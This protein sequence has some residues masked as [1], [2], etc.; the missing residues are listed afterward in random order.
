MRLGLLPTVLVALAVPATASAHGFGRLYNLPVPFWLYAWAAAATLLLS[1]VATAFLVT[2]AAASQPKVKKEAVLTL[3]N[4]GWA[5]VLRRLLLPLK[6][7]SVFLLGLTIATGLWGNIDPLQ[8]FSMTS[9]WVVFLLGFTYLTALIGNTW[10]LLNPWRVLADVIGSVVPSLTRGRLRYP[11]VLG[12]WPA[13]VLYLG[14]IWIEL[15]SRA[16]PPSLAHALLAYSAINLVGVW[17]VGAAAWF[18]HCEFFSVF[19]RLVALHAPIHYP[20]R[21]RWDGSAAH[22]GIRPLFSGLW[23]SRPARLSTVVFALAMLATT[24]F[25]G[26]RATQWWVRLFWAD[27]TGLVTT[28]AG[29]HPMN[30]YI[31][32]RAWYVAWETACLIAL[33]FLYFAAYG[34]S[35]VLAKAL[36]RSARPLRELALDFG[37]TLLPIALVYH[38]THYATLLL[39]QGLK[40]LHLVSDPF[41]WGWDLFGTASHFRAP[42]LPDMGWVWHTQVGLILFGHIVSLVAAHRVALR[43]WPTRGQVLLSQ[44][45][46]L[47]IMVLF[48]VVGLWILAQPLT[49]ELMR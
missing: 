28:L 15:F 8:N 34:A 5:S 20:R 3:G 39:T 23:R 4:A 31:R 42:M 32:L 17:L 14:L 43:I 40:I 44:L 6:T 12:D 45:P 27:T 10:A 30:D 1:F 22:F 36:T 41:G 13:L 33:P 18:Q 35:L 19:L 16:T 47:G 7:V 49:V 48:T 46:M 21:A 11:D 29:V 37:Y 25:D 24:A 2:E 38:A 26:L 9:F